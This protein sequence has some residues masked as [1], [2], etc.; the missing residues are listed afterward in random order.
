MAFQR[1]EALAGADV[2]DLRRVVEGGRHELVAVSIEV[3]R[4]DLGVVALETENFL[5]GLH[6]PQLRRVVHGARGDEHAVWVEREAHDLHLVALERVVALARV[7]V[8]NLRLSVEGASHDFVSASKRQV[9]HK[10]K[11]NEEEDLPVGVVEGHRVDDVGVLVERKQ[12]LARVGVPDLA[13]AVVAAGDEAV[14]R[15]VEGA[16]GQRQ[17]V[18]SQDFEEVEV[19]ALV[20]LDLLD[21]FVD[22]LA[23]LR[24]RRG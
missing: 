21:E 24:A 3:E 22:Q 5:P 1:E 16:V 10:D 13:R 6:V 7:R 9:S 4:Y 19:L 8:P 12:L 2:P 14:A 17:D 15:L 11:Q 20:R 18:S 23:Q